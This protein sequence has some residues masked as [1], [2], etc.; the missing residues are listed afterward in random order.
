LMRSCRGLPNL[1]HREGL[2]LQFHRRRW[3]TQS[4]NEQHSTPPAQSPGSTVSRRET[5]LSPGPALLE[6]PSNPGLGSISDSSLGV[7]EIDEMSAAAVSA[8]SRLRMSQVQDLLTWILTVPE[9]HRSMVY[10]NI[11]TGWVFA[12]AEE[13]VYRNAELVN[14]NL[15]GPAYY[16]CGI[17]S[18]GGAFLS[19]NQI[20]HQSS[21]RLRF[22][23]SKRC[24][25]RAE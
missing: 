25:S 18:N 1:I 23:W 2:H 13:E 3:V 5:S 17:D 11:N 20:L 4:L 15:F 6:E 22:F 14:R 7:P 10:Y 16:V 24:A 9:S 12:L 21:Y 8:G 19:P